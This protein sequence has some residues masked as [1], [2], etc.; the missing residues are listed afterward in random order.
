MIHGDLLVTCPGDQ[1]AP[2]LCD[3]ALLKQGRH[4]PI[5]QHCTH[6][7]GCQHLLALQGCSDNTFD[8]RSFDNS[9]I[10]VAS[11]LQRRHPQKNWSS[12]H[13]S[14]LPLQSTTEKM[15]ITQLSFDTSL[16]H[17]VSNVRLNSAHGDWAVADVCIYSLHI[18]E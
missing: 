14:K 10:E 8:S 17:K 12:L 5:V 2:M 16:H 3:P 13:I 4:H 11:H 18:H 9:G 15:E 6:C 7:R 1:G